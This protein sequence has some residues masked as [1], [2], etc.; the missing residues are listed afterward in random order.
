MDY[1]ISDLHLMDRGVI[2]FERTEFNTIEE[3]DAYLVKMW[4]STIV[5]K[6]DTIYFLGDLHDNGRSRKDI[7]CLKNIV[8]KL[9]GHKIMIKGNHDVYKDQDYLDMG[10]EKVITGP[11]YYKPYLILSH[12]PCR[13]AFRNPYVWNVHGHLHNA[14]LELDN[15]K[16]VSTKHIDY[17]PMKLTKFAEKIAGKVQKR[18]ECFMEEWYS[19]FYDFMK[20]KLYYDDNGRVDSR[21]TRERKEPKDAETN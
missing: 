8:G 5:N 18:K 2:K 17:K 15:Y 13:E 10:F 4:N 20:Y 16:C 3:H 6:D 1:V 19:V 9:R 7:E 14:T 21:T 12:E 11:Y